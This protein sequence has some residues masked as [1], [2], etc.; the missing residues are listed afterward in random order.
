MKKKTAVALSLMIHAVA[1]AFAALFDASSGGG[2]VSRADGDPAGPLVV[3]LALNPVAEDSTSTAPA[4]PPQEEIKPEPAPFSDPKGLDLQPLQPAPTLPVDPPSAEVSSPSGTGATPIDESAQIQSP[5][6]NTVSRPV[7]RQSTIRDGASGGESEKIGAGSRH[8]RDLR[9]QFTPPR[10]SQNPA[11]AYPREARRKRQEGTAFLC[12]IVSNTG[13]PI[14]IKLLRSTG[15]TALD[16]SAIRAVRGWVFQP[17]RLDNK[18][19]MSKVAVPV[20]FR[21]AK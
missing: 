13:H 14:D 16:E 21:L 5:P 4:A 15:S 2:E 17:A 8:S 7:E 3:S 1:L 12:V 10:Y 6:L 11:P 19:V 9:A 18:N 20:R